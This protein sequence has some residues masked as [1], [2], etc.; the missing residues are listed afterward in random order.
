MFARLLPS[1]TLTL[2]PW[3]IVLSICHCVAVCVACTNSFW[4]K[5]RGKQSSKISEQNATSYS[6]DA[7]EP[8]T[9][10]LI[11]NNFG[12]RAPKDK[13]ERIAD[14]GKPQALSHRK[15]VNKTSIYASRTLFFSFHSVRF[16][17]RTRFF[18]FIFYE[19]LKAWE[20][21][22]TFHKSTFALSIPLTIYVI[23]TSTCNKKERAQQTARVN[24]GND[25]DDEN[26]NNNNEP[27]K[28]TSMKIKSKQSKKSRILPRSPAL[29]L[30]LFRFHWAFR[31][32]IQSIKM[33]HWLWPRVNIKWWTECA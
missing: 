22:K 31:Y 23:K 12:Y 7:E 25:D 10:H 30:S 6:S 14:G 8:A 24:D 3:P 28:I 18:L 26:N 20:S 2:H 27:T 1:A 29:S 13:I 9:F 19:F 17:P 16:S 33:L 15:L 32:S 21:V 4:T 11:H 5:W